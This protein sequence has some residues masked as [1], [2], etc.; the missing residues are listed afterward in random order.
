MPRIQFVIAGIAPVDVRRRR[1]HERVLFWRLVAFWGLRRKDWELSMGY[2]ARGRKMPPVLPSTEARR[3][4]AM[5]EADPKAPYLTPARRASRTRSLLTAHAEEDR[6]VFTW[7]FDEHT[8]DEWG[9]ILGYHRRRGRQ[10]DVIGI[11]AKGKAWVAAKARQEWRKIMASPAVVPFSDEP[12]RGKSGVLLRES[13]PRPRLPKRAKASPFAV[14][15]MVLLTALML[16]FAVEAIRR[17]LGDEFDVIIAEAE[18]LELVSVTRDED[19]E[20]T[21]VAA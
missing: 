20:V 3:R 14:L 11:S 15:L 9:V 5:G 7:A 13:A 18:R 17:L 12:T 21:A 16:G 19:G 2:N 4:S 6:A 10:Y 1:P 8:G